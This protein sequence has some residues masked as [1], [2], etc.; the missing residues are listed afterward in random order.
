MFDGG[1]ERQSGQSQNFV[2]LHSFRLAVVLI[3]STYGHC[4]GDQ[5]E[6]RPQCA[7]PCTYVIKYNRRRDV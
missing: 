4:D 6:I 2:V 3:Y 5:A 1:E 7:D